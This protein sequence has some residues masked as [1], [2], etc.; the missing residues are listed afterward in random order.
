[1]KDRWVEIPGFATCVTSIAKMSDTKAV[2]PNFCAFVR[3][4]ERCRRTFMKSSR[5]PTTPK[6]TV[7]NTSAMPVTV[8]RCAVTRDTR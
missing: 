6:P 8:N 1:M 3:P 7:A 5:N 2:P 4:S